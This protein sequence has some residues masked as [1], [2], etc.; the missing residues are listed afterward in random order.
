ECRYYLTRDRCLERKGLETVEAEALKLLR[1]HEETIKEMKGET[2]EERQELAEHGYYR[3]LLGLAYFVNNNFDSKK[4][5]FIQEA[6]SPVQAKFLDVTEKAGLKGI[7]GTTVTVGDLDA[8]GKED[9]L[10]EGTQVLKNL[11]DGSFKDIT[12]D[13]NLP[14][15]RSAL[16]ADFNN[17]GSLD[18][19]QIADTGERV[20][21]SDG[22]GRFKA[23]DNPGFVKDNFITG[24][25][26]AAD[27]NGD[28]LVDLYM[29]KFEERNW[30]RKSAP[31][32][33]G[34]FLYLNRKKG[35]FEDVSEKAGIRKAP[36]MLGR[37][38]SV[39]DFDG[40]GDP[41]IYVS[42]FNLNFDRNFLWLNDGKGS[43]ADVAG[44]RNVTGKP[45]TYRERQYHG[46]SRGSVFGDVDGDGDMDIFVVCRCQ[47]R[48][49]DILG[50]S[51]LLVNQGAEK[52]FTFE[53]RFSTSG[54]RFA[55]NPADCSMVDFDNDGDLDIYVTAPGESAQSFLYQNDGEGKFADVTWLTRTVAFNASGHAWFDLD[56]D[57]DMDLV[58]IGKDGLRLFK[59]GMGKR[60]GWI[61]LKLSG[62]TSN[63]S[64][65]GARVT[66][67]AGKK[68]QRRDIVC[69]RGG[70][71]A[72]DSLIVHFGL[73]RTK[74]KVDVEIRWPSGTAQTLKLDASQKHIIREK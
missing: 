9:L 54:I 46:H 18:I 47:P 15:G 60:N 58:T 34:D 12:A 16:L 5:I 61:E 32:I 44:E 72:Q 2:P 50:T 7:V 59:N 65:V 14:K 33:M 25:A 42:N 13:V 11:G 36:S 73:G 38:A 28:G 22:T 48:H 67:K 26:A 19:L 17:D 37:G 30:D 20:L 55:E 52:K 74:G 10:V 3:D 40:D 49:I 4:N 6:P 41:D 43:F 29:T 8:D 45:V 21:L 39:C 23:V 64:A 66:L 70:A 56:G 51:M 53:D 31:K 68:T 1:M 69:G 24:S 35:C 27:F 71:N 62:G 57:G 63:A